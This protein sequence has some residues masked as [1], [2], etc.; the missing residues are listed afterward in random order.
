LIFV[1]FP[2]GKPIE[3]GGPPHAMAT[4]D[5]A[6]ALGDDFLLVSDDEAD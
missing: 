4:D 6:L 2:E 1:V 5:L 3:H